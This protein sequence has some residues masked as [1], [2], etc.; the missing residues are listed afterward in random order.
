MKSTTTSFVYALCFCLSISAGA[1]AQTAPTAIERELAAKDSLLFDIAFHTCNVTNLSNLFDDNFVFFHDNGLLQPTQT[2]P[3]AQF[4]ESLKNNC[5]GMGKNGVAMRREVV[6]GTMQVFLTS[7]TEAVQTGVQRFYMKQGSNKEQIVEESKFTRSWHKEGGNWK[8]ALET[9]YLVN[10]HPDVVASDRYV[11]EPYVPS[12]IE[13][14]NTIVKLDSIY[15][16]TYNHSKPAE[17]DSLTSDNFEFYHD[18]GGLM[19]SKKLY[20]ESIQ[21]NIFGKVTRTLTKG[22]IEVYE[23]PGYG[24]VEFGYHSFRNISEPGESRP[25]RFVAIWHHQGN[26]WQMARVIS[27]HQ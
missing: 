2:Q 6:K 25:S 5:D 11:P 24:A 10:G 22:S 4:K 21:K 23:I 17:M 18:H 27:L 8:L 7:A 15:F 16:D 3:Y 20:L 9:D 1:L 26:R 19:T 12:S 14:Y 13:L